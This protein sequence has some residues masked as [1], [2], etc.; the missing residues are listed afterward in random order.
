MVKQMKTHINIVCEA[1]D[2]NDNHLPTITNATQ[3]TPK[4]QFIKEVIDAF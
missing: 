3:E 4:E 2:R 1:R